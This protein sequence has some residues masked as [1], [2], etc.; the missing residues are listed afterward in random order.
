MRALRTLVLVPLL[1]AC[2]KFESQSIGLVY[3][4][5]AD[6]ITLH[7]LYFG[8]DREDAKEED[9]EVLDDAVKHGDFCLLG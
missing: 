8:L 3:D 2:L 7:L 4:A 1:C 5:T 9:L 6:R